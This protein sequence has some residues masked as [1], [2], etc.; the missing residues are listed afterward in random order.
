MQEEVVTTIASTDASRADVNLFG[1]GPEDPIAGAIGDQVPTENTKQGEKGPQDV[2]TG[3]A[4]G[5]AAQDGEPTTETG[6]APTDGEEGA[7]DDLKVVLSIR[8]GR[9][10]IGV[11]RPSSDPHIEF[12][13]DSDLAG[14]A[15]EVPA[16]VER[17]AASWE[18]RPK[19]P[20]Y[21]RPAPAAK[22]R[23]Q[24]GRAAGGSANAAGGESSDSLQ[25]ALTLY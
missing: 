16:V 8:E 20:T 25:Q 17:A 2:V 10:T 6:E 5:E 24:R 21:V 13:D 4:D 1:D 15:Q 12:F 9:A 23:N 3:N 7:S 11:Q 18:Q 19:Y 22:R 14:L